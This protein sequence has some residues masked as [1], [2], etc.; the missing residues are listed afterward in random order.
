MMDK[1]TY[2]SKLL[3]YLNYK[4]LLNDYDIL[5]IQIIVVDTNWLI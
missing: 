2:K 5:L 1:K 3:I 4:I